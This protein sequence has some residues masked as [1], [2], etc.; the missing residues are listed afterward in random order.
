MNTRET[1]T[2]KGVENVEQV[3]LNQLLKAI[4]MNILW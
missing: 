1:E 3:S 4:Y 2:C